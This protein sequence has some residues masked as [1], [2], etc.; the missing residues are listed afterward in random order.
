M[1]RH[2][3]VLTTVFLSI[4]HS[5]AAAEQPSAA[6]LVV[7]DFL[8]AGYVTDG[9]VSY[10]TELQSALDAALTSHQNIVFPPIVYRLDDPQGL[11]VGSDL[12]LW[13]QGATFELSADIRADG[14]AFRGE[15]VSDVRFLGGTIIG[16]NEEWPAGTNLRGIYLTG[17]CKQ[18]RI[19]GMAFRDL[20]SNGVGIFGTDGEHPARDVWLTDTIIDNCC[21]VYGDYQAP[22]GELHGPEPGS[23]REDQG[24]VAFYHVE[25]FVVRGCR[26]EDSRSDGTHFYRC[27]NGRFTDNHV[28][29][30][31][32]GGY[33][34]ETCEHVLAT[35]NIIRDN[36]S[37]GVTIERGIEGEF[38]ERVT[39]SGNQHG[40]D[41]ENPGERRGVS[42]PRESTSR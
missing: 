20:S 10:Q 40:T 31:K 34:V 42:P 19:D 35:N 15:A 17:P 9:S 36:G 21:N 7:T 28:L 26:F 1:L 32:M 8:P 23:G 29:R 18:I 6:A 5:C 25:D 33:F 41:H 13:M 24:L 39:I 30:A 3:L 16:H 22:A 38:P 12:T 4:V 27:A 37:R 2:L 11:R 14:Q